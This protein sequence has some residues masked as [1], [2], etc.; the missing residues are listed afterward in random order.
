M[1][2]RLL[3]LT[4]SCA[5]WLPA[6]ST[7]GHIGGADTDAAVA[8]DGSISDA[9]IDA[10]DDA[11]ID[12]PAAGAELH[13]RLDGDD[14]NPAASSCGCT[15]ACTSAAHLSPSAPTTR[16]PPRLRQQPLADGRRPH[17]RLLRRDRRRRTSPT[18]GR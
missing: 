9:T 18:S 16:T 10:P 7:D 11:A 14:G 4:P 8:T 6:G 17:H 2:W 1:T 5:G 12:A 3:G 15:A 13:V